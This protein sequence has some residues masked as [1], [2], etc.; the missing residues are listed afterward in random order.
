MVEAWMPVTGF[1]SLYE[2]SDSGRVRSLQRKTTSGRILKPTADKDGYLKVSLSKNNRKETKFV[3]RLVAAAFVDNPSGLTIVNHKDENKQNNRADNLEYCTIQYNSTYNDVH[4]RR[5]AAQRKAIIQ[6]DN[7]GRIVA[8][9]TG[10]VEIEQRLG[11]RGGNI[12]SA[13]RG[14]RKTAYGFRWR[15]ADE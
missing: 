12:T 8:I 10:R 13:C 15:Y 1:E 5:G 11:V 7:E 14:K 9:W 6:Y 4:R 3:H 2:V